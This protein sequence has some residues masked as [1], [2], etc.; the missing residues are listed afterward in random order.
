MLMGLKLRVCSSHVVVILSG[1]WKL[2][3]VV[4]FF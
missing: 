4:A 3:D 2:L 1:S